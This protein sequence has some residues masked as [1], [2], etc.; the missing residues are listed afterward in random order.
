[1]KSGLL[2]LAL[3]GS[4]A[5]GCFPNPMTMQGDSKSMIAV[6]RDHPYEEMLK[7]GPPGN[8]MDG[9]SPH[10]MG[11]GGPSPR[12]LRVLGKRALKESCSNDAH[13]SECEQA[14]GS[15][16]TLEQCLQRKASKPAGAFSSLHATRIPSVVSTSRMF[17]NVFCK[18]WPVTSSVFDIFYRRDSVLSDALSNCSSAGTSL[19]SARRLAFV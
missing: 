11:M 10:L 6:S 3:L 5:R 19:G 12:E 1:M 2:S 7:S 8:R 4:T 16:K 9:P 14:K 17:S 15:A 13:F 18:L